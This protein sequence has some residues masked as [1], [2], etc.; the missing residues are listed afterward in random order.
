MLAADFRS[1]LDAQAAVERAY[2][3]PERWTRMSILNVARCGFFSSDRS[4]RE[5][6]QEIWNVGPIDVPDHSGEGLDASQRL[7]QPNADELAA[8]PQFTPDEDHVLRDLPLLVG[9]DLMHATHSGSQGTLIE[10]ATAVAAPAA[11]ARFL[12][13]SVLVRSLV[14]SEVEMIERSEQLIAQ[15]VQGYDLRSRD[16]RAG[17]HDDVLNQCR[18]AMDLL[19]SRVSRQDANEYARWLLL[20]GERV[21]EASIEPQPGR[22]ERQVSDAEAAALREIAA[23]LRVEG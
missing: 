10:L 2:A 9:L 3:D 14:L 6:C 12:A 1:Y 17:V 11:T 8:V 19:E 5:Y 22:P 18:E 20:V 15:L 13:R 16:G 21:A 7:G 23:A 4:I